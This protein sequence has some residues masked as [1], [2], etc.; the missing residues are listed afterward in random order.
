MMYDCI[1]MKEENGKKSLVKKYI[2][3]VILLV[4]VL[5]V[6][7]GNVVSRASSKVYGV[8][9]KVTYAPR[10]TMMIMIII[11]ITTMTMITPGDRK[12]KNVTLW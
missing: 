6:E 10:C 5:S 2:P 7:V 3:I 11:N 9:S 12:E 8:V 1:I 4:L